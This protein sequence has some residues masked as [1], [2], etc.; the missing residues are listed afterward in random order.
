VQII[1]G[2][3]GLKRDPAGASNPVA[4]AEAFSSCVAQ[5]RS[6]GDAVLKDQEANKQAGFQKWRNSKKNECK[7][8]DLLRFI[9]DRRNADLHEGYSPLAFTMHPFSFNSETVGPAPSPAANLFV[10]GTGPYW[11]VDQGTPHE[12]RLPVESMGNVLFS[13]AIVNPPT[14]HLG[15][16][17]PSTEPGAILRLAEGYYANLLFEARQTFAP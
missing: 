17:L 7:N 11:I 6:V 2:P 16:A 14:M 13:V 5:V 4:F 1:S 8:D 9:N 10:D 3:P 12:R 15:S